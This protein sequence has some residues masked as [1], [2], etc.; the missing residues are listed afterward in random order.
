MQLRFEYINKKPAA[1]LLKD[2]KNKMKK[3]S[4]ESSVNDDSEED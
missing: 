1:N 2:R 4:D 3:F